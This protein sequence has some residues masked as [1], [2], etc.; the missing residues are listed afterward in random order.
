M[1]DDKQN[2]Q[3]TSK[4]ETKQILGAKLTYAR[5]KTFSEIY[6]NRVVVKLRVRSVFP[7]LLK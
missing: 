6:V 7:N 1:R 3:I 2:I 4:E 5:R